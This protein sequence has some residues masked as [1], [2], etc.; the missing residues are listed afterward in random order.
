MTLEHGTRGY[1]NYT[2]V[3]YCFIIQRLGE[4]KPTM[5]QLENEIFNSLFSFLGR[6]CDL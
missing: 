3:N 4:M 2:E 6:Y 1:D 5:C